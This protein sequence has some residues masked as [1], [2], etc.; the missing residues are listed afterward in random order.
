MEVSVVHN[1][2]METVKVERLDHLGIIAGIIKDLG[3]EDCDVK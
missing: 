1:F 3:I 2:A